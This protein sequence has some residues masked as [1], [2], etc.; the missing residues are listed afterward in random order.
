MI[1]KLALLC[2][3]LSLLSWSYYAVYK[4]AFHEGLSLGVDY[5]WSIGTLVVKGVKRGD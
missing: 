2:F 5:G 4:Y 3:M 1:K